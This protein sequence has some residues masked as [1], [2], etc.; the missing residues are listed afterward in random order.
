MT[1]QSHFCDITYMWNK[2][3]TNDTN[4]LM[5]K[6]E[7]DSQILKTNLWLP[8]E[9]CVGGIN[10]ELETHTTIYEIDNQ[11]GPMVQH[12]E[13]I[14]YLVIIYKG[15]ESEKE[16]MCIHVCVSE[17]LCYTPETNII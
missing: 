7:I 6:I 13:Y 12:R 9:K 10:Q 3:K 1:Q 11:Q 4:E 5:Y 8:K 2:K 16:Y 14:H 17:S 15:K